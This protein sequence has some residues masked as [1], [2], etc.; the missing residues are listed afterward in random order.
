[1]NSALEAA[2]KQARTN[3]GKMVED[4]AELISIRSISSD[5]AF[6]DECVRCAEW[7]ADRLRQISCER[8]EIFETTRSPIVYAYRSAP[9]PDAP[10]ILIYGHYDIQT[11]DPLSAWTS[12]P[13]KAEISGDQLFGRGTSDMKGPLLAAFAAIEAILAADSLPVGIKFVIEGDEET[14][15]EP[16]RWFLKEHGD[17]LIADTCLNVDAGMLGERIPTIV[18]GLRGSSSC[19]VRIKGP[20][21][22][23]HDGMFGGVVENPI[24]VLARLIAGLQD[25]L[26]RITLPGFYDSV[27]PI[28][29]TE[30]RAAQRHPHDAGF[31]LHASGSP[32]LI[33]DPEYSPVERIGARPSMNVRWFK[34]GERKN[35][36]PV[37]AEAR[38]SF[39]IVPDQD[40]HEIHRMLLDYLSKFM[41]P[42]VHWEVENVITEPGVLVDLETPGVRALS[43]ALKAT[44]GVDPIYQRIGGSIPVVGELKTLLGIDSALTGFSLPEDH[45]HGP[46]EHVHLPTL[47]KGEEAIVRFLYTVS[48]GD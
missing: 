20:E 28:S 37:E 33:D 24:Q 35:A 23:L 21:F 46:N 14:S 4:L 12:D 45:I 13:F 44:W 7:I 1:V 29:E 26:G 19:T 10:T 18:Y 43:A 15:G 6:H 9:A 39:R 40:P 42:T 25:E 38:I 48:E 30:R 11:P 34:G 2:L 32:G 22:D 27:R 8:V 3:S 36:I 17:L 41:P 47:Y 5:K 16:M 31:Y